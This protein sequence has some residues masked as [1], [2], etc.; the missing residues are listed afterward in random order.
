MRRVLF[1]TAITACLAWQPA[2]AQLYPQLTPLP[3]TTAPSVLR[4]QATQREVRERFERGVAAEMRG[5]WAK[6]ETEFT[7]IIALAP[8]E[9]QRSTAHYDLGIA[10]V[11]LRELDLA[12]A[13]FERAIALDPGFLAAHAN[14]VT[15]HL[16]HG[17]LAA[18]RTVADRFVA[19]APDSARALYGRG[20]IA[21]QAGDA[22][23]ALHDFGMLLDRNPHFATAHYDLALA[24][25]KL[26]RLADAER[27]LQ[28]AL[29]IAPHFA[30]AQFALGT[31]LLRSGRRDEARTAFDQAARAAQD[32]T[33][34]TLALSLRDSIVR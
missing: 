15:A 22:T 24:E 20:L 26:G 18:A 16:L 12:V 25:I 2:V 8:P 28:S 11:Q 3:R 21:L 6:A 5:D 19:L 23:T 29:G 9:P 14:L 1:A 31:V 30:R 27:E 7:R 13:S 10:Q 17:D 4:A 34:R 32:A 33:L